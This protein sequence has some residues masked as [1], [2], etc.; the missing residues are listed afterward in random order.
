VVNVN[1]TVT[2]NTAQILQ[3][4]GTL[5]FGGVDL[6]SFRDG[7]TVTI[8][9]ELSFTR[10]DY[11]VAEIDAE[12]TLVTCEVNTIL[13]ESTTRNWAVAIGG[14]T[15]SSSSSSSSII[16]DFGPELALNLVP[17][18]FLGMSEFDKTKNRTITFDRAARIGSTATTFR[19]GVEVL[20]PVTWKV[21]IKTDGSFFKVEDNQ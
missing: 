11:A 17:L 18:I 14:N 20:L 10:S 19:R 4:A 1:N 21:F 15:S 6:G 13:E 5:T 9:H 16:W 2:V 12:S 7:I 8:A 3:G